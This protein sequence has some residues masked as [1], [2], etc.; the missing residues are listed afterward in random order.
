MGVK[1]RSAY[2]IIKCVAIAGRQCVMVL[3]IRLA[4]P[5]GVKNIQ[6]HNG[7]FLIDNALNRTPT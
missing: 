7:H 2:R 5:V 4:L 3:I 1:Y 6:S